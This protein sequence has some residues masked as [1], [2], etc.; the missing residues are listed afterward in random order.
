M[1][2]QTKKLTKKNIA[3]EAM[4]VALK[5][6]TKAIISKIEEL[7]GEGIECR[8]VVGKW[9]LASILKQRKVDVL[10]SKKV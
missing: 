1:D 8:V 6:E 7:E 9:M 2:D 4:V 10:K 5:E 3:L